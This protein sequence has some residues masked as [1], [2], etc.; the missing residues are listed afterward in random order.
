MPPGTS[1][2]SGRSRKIGRD[3]LYPAVLTLARFCAAASRRASAATPPE[4]TVYRPRFTSCALSAETSSGT[5]QGG[6]HGQPMPGSRSWLAPI[7]QVSVVPA[8]FA[9]RGPSPPEAQLE[10][11]QQP[12][13]RRIGVVL[14]ELLD[15]RAR[16][17][18]GRLRARFLTR[19]EVRA[20]AR[21][22]CAQRP[23]A[24]AEPL[25][26]RGGALLGILEQLRQVALQPIERLLLILE[27]RGA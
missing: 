27:D 13:L 18:F 12:C 5:E 17:R 6:C 22:E 4:A 21:D 7:G 10:V 25:L 14:D 1:L 16:Q 19:A 23:L 20:E 9:S 3:A 15:Q 24:G 26:E 11:A 8:A 2:A